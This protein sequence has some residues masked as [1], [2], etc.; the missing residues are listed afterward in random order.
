MG[1]T[2]RFQSYRPWREPI[3]HDHRERLEEHVRRQCRMRNG[4]FLS[5]SA[6]APLDWIL[7]DLLQRQ[8]W[9]K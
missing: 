3:Y 9:L 2:T 1:H 5:V 4:R 6:D 8:G 7:F